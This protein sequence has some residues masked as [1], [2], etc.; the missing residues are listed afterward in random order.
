M[1]KKISTAFENPEDVKY[2]TSKNIRNEDGS[3]NMVRFM[4]SLPKDYLISL[5][6]YG[7]KMSIQTFLELGEVEGNFDFVD[8]IIVSRPVD[9]TSGWFWVIGLI[10]L[11]VITLISKFYE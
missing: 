6:K 9:T 4:N 8:E 2:L 11:F 7:G 3:I 1:N 5:Q 10:V